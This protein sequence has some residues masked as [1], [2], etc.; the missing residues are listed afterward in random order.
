MS[1]HTGLFRAYALPVVWLFALPLFA[2]WFSGH[3]KERYD[4]GF[5]EAVE[6]QIAR[7]ASL[8]EQEREGVLRFYREHP[9]SVVCTQ[10]DV[11]TADFRENL[12]EGCS[13]YRQF[14]WIRKLALGSIALGV[15]SLL[16]ALACALTS[17]VSR[18]MQYLSVLVGWNVLK[19]VGALQSVM[20]GGAMVFLSFWMTALWFER[21]SL[22]LIGGVGVVVAFAVWRVLVAIFR[23]PPT[24]IDVEG[25]LIAE[26]E[27][28]EF[29]RR[30]RALCAELDT[31]PPEHVV[32]GIDDN[33]FV[34]EGVLRIGD[35]TL[36][37][38]SL[39]VSLSLLRILQRGE[40]EA[41]LAHEM[42]HF[43]GGDTAHGKRLAPLMARFT[44][45]LH[46]LHEGVVT[47]PIFH[48]MAGFYSLISLS[49][50]RSNRE[51]EFA[52]DATAAKLTSADDIGRSLIKIGAYA[53][54]RGRVEKDLF[55]NDRQHAEIGIAQRVAA[56]FA[57]YATTEAVHF[58]LHEAITPHPFDS[59]PRLDERLRNV[60]AKLQREQYGEVLLAPA[61]SSWADT[62][63]RANDIERRLW[64]AYE[65]RFT[66]AHELALAYRYLPANDVERS[67]V[68]RFFPTLTFEGKEQHPSVELSYE[69]ITYAEWE[70]PLPL[71][72]VA[73]LAVEE[74]LFV[75]YLD[76]KLK[77]A[78][79]FGG[80]RSLRLGQI[81]DPDALLEA[82]S[83]YVG[84]AD[85]AQRERSDERAA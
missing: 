4:Q 44:H 2:L 32:A 28:P 42:A 70:S 81:A 18:P 64:T 25:E 21:Y 1:S 62:I 53:S 61:G 27:A 31:A 15:A 57:G 76:L 47:R 23:K 34:T 65:Q 52:A 29:W 11:E 13:D 78:G 55:E 71:A 19:V 69:R 3:A 67:H 17:F 14:E 84:R 50:G 66:A 38:R 12:G 54:Y 20:Q 77:N 68:E 24:G 73:S 85:A 40:A 5:F 49:L 10:D 22:K 58:D 48:F 83:R 80:K 45:Y 51:R 79:L 43:Q 60:G 72:E 30:I 39:Y 35:K 26:A 59:H 36:H 63:S 75:R 82:V 7:D 46:A 37:G 41:V 6:P 9:P 8:S 16:F 33:F 56:G 74:R